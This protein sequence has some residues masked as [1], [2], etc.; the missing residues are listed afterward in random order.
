MFVYFWI[1]YV[2]SMCDIVF[3]GKISIH[4]AYEEKLPD[5]MFMLIY[6]TER[7]E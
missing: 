7:I 6:L 5:I 4:A 2:R 3:V 1:L